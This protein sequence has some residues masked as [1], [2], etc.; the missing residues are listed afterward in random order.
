[1]PN[2]FQDE[3]YRVTRLVNEE[4]ERFFD[5]KLASTKKTDRHIHAMVEVL[6]E[7][8]L[9]GGKHI[10]PFLTWCGYR[11]AGGKEEGKIIR[12]AAG[13]GLLHFY[14]L[15]LDDMA[16]R[17]TLRHGGPTLEEYYKTAL[18]NIPQKHRDHYGRSFSEIAGALL[19]T[20]AY[21]LVRTSG[22]DPK[23]ILEALGILNKEMFEDT[24]AGWL[25]HMHQNWQNV[26]DATEEEFIK[27]LNLVT[28]QYTFVG[29]LLIGAT[30][31]GTGKK[32]FPAL[33]EFGLHVGTAFQIQDDILGLFGDKTVTGKAVGN[34]LREGKKTLLIQYAYRHG[35]SHE[36]EVVERALGGSVDEKTLIQVQQ[37]VQKTGGLEHGKKLAKGYVEKG[38][39]IIKTSLPDK[40]TQEIL[41]ELAQFI[42]ERKY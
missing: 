36:R 20:Y 2:I 25:I 38:I 1:M 15:N 31:A 14:I 34:D 40:Q 12:A 5:Q 24:A 28:A 39:E 3:F 29:P 41:F 21:E 7:Y 22:F 32:Y 11:V 16:D 4:I 26:A 23:D 17:D 6:K 13:V 27:G 19:N 8:S 18:T 9:R 30:L 10:R 35:N 33:R 42:I 37:I